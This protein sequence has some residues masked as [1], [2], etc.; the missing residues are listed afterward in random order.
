MKTVLGREPQRA[1]RS[2]TATARRKSTMFKEEIEDLKNRHMTRLVLH[3]VFSADEATDS[4]LHMGRD[5]PRQARRVPARLVTPGIDHAFVCGPFQM[6][7]EAEAALLAAGV[8]ENAS[9]SSASAW[10]RRPGPAARRARRARG[11]SP[12]TPSGPAS[13]SCATA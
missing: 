5:G 4:P 7:D 11:P 12:V 8:A 6:N 13:P 9:T 1:S 3:H 10:R 2:S